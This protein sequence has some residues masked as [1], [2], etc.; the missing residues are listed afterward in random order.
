MK[1]CPQCGR[2]YDASMMFCLDDGAELLYGPAPMDEPQTAVL[3]GADAMTRQQLLTNDQTPIFPTGTEAEPQ[4]SFDSKPERQSLSAHRAAQPQEELLKSAHRVANPLIAVAVVAIVLIGGFFSYR[5]FN[6]ANSGQI[7]SIAVMPFVNESGNADVEYLSDG[8]TETLIG[9]LT[10]LP[11]LNV[12]AR[13]SVFRY[14]G[15]DADAKTVGKELGV[16]AVLNG[17]VG[18][19]GDQVTLSLELV[20]VAT[21]NAI[22]SQQYTRKQ[23]DLVSL[24]SEVA[25][26]V[27]SKLKMKLSGADVAKVEKTYT[28]NPEAYQLYL[29]G[30]F[31]WNRRSGDSLKQAVEFFNQAI[32]KDANYA[33][34]YSG[35]AES[36][37]LF[38]N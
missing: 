21:E 29:K 28:A 11:N 4:R 16:Q 3:S 20:D 5:Y 9:S 33:L 24:Q 1:Q 8:M 10:Q 25:R 6:A 22:W 32:E 26:D 14:K 17:R 27:S 34:A 38:S 13:S 15:K 19:R 37:S 35:L 23:S 2:E 18:Q 31:Q 30:R 7:N 36:Y 12:K